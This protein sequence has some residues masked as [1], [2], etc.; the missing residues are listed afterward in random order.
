MF[1][2]DSDG[3][4]EVFQ[5]Y[6]KAG[7]PVLDCPTHRL[8]PPPLEG[9]GGYPP[10]RRLGVPAGLVIRLQTNDLKIFGLCYDGHQYQGSGVVDVDKVKQCHLCRRDSTYGPIFG[11]SF[12]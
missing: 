2:I 6:P 11:C 8:I 9:T 7:L 5:H 3:T 12:I 10:V 1:I 4:A